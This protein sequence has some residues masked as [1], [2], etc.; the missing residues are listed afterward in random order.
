MLADL[1]AVGEQPRGRRSE[2]PSGSSTRIPFQSR[3]CRTP[4]RSRTDRQLLEQTVRVEEVLDDVH[5]HR[6]A[7]P[8]A[9][10]VPR[11]LH[12]HDAHD[13][14]V[15]VEHRPAAVAGVAPTRPSAGSAGLPSSS[16]RAAESD[17]AVTVT[18]GH[19]AR[20]A[21]RPTSTCR[22][23]GN[24][25]TCTGRPGSTASES[26]SGRY[27]RSAAVTCSAARSVSA[28]SEATTCASNTPVPAAAADRDLDAPVLDARPPPRPR[29]PG[30][31]APRPRRPRGGSSAPA[32]K[33]R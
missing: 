12:P 25:S 20:V 16:S 17:P 18:L 24:P 10:R 2:K 7:R 31:T 21:R 27:G 11:E 33:A 5:G 29:G 26:P 3:V 6:E 4:G 32:P 19:G 14:A 23:N 9:R 28:T 15:L 1:A 30:S 8:L 22:P 13:V